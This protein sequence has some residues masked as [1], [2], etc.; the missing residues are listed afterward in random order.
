MGVNDQCALQK[1]WA[2][3]VSMGHSRRIANVRGE[4]AYPLTPVV[5]LHRN[6]STWWA[7]NGREQLQ[8]IVGNVIG[9]SRRGRWP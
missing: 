9:Y 6:E 2:T 7:N 4:S 8:Q 3:H 1:S 5:A